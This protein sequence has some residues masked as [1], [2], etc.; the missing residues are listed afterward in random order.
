MLRELWTHP[1]LR[2]GGDSIDVAF[3]LV[4]FGQG[5]N[6]AWHYRQAWRDDDSTDDGF[7]DH[8][9][10]GFAIDPRAVVEDLREVRPT[11]IVSAAPQP[12]HSGL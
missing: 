4:K 12:P 7:E 11:V 10:E 8:V 2:E 5:G 6:A 3:E 1:A 9:A